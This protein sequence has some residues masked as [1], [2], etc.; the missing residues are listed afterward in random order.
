MAL[1][2]PHISMLPTSLHFSAPSGF[3]VRLRL[4]ALSCRAICVF[5]A[6]VLL[7]VGQG[8]AQEKPDQL[9]DLTR[10]LRSPDKIIRISAAEALK[11]IGPAAKEAIP[12]LIEALKDQDAEVRL[13]AAIALGL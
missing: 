9:Y 10:K 7:L 6:A 3:A 2:L 8:R 5:F 4:T 11:K 1:R 13:H 12:A